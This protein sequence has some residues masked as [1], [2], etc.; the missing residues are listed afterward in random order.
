MAASM[1]A[2]GGFESHHQSAHKQQDRD[3]G[4]SAGRRVG[5][6]IEGEYKRED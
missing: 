3:S 6:T 2:M 1:P 5:R 4:S